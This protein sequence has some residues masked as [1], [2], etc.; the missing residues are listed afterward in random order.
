MQRERRP[1]RVGL[2]LGAIIA[3]RGARGEERAES[4]ARR[5]I[6]L[7]VV[8]RDSLHARRAPAV[9]RPI[10]LGISALAARLATPEVAR[11]FAEIGAEFAISNVF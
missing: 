1:G 3:V 9:D 7:A 5:G 8:H 11:R 2:Q 10:D 6:T 4:G